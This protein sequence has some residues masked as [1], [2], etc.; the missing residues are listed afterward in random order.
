M[1]V[2][3]FISCKIRM[4]R[5]T[6]VSNGRRLPL[7]PCILSSLVK[8]PV[9]L[10]HG[11]TINIYG[12]IWNIN[13]V[14]YTVIWLTV[15]IHVMHVSFETSYSY[16]IHV[17]FEISTLWHIH[18]FICYLFITEVSYSSFCRQIGVG[19][20]VH[21]WFLVGY[22]WVEQMFGK[23]SMPSPVSDFFFKIH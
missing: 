18:L 8:I 21:C 11:W 12:V 9:L 15:N 1:L 6:L 13:P 10:K 14:T 5:L 19:F 3:H 16:V 7:L 4:L 20:P 23:I 2:Y 22:R 17:P